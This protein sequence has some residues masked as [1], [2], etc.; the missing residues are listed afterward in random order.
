MEKRSFKNVFA[1]SKFVRKRMNRHRPFSLL[2][3]ILHQRVKREWKSVKREKEREAEKNLKQPVLIHF[4][5]PRHFFFFYKSRKSTVHPCIYFFF[6]SLDESSVNAR[7]NTS[8]SM[9][10]FFFSFFYNPSFLRPSPYPSLPFFFL[11]SLPSASSVLLF[12]A[13]PSLSLSRFDCVDYRG[14]GT[15]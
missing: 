15:P 1:F 2:T 6:I 7:V 3:K 11:S 8:R 5:L 10:A 4:H 13:P 12:L 14:V 9:L